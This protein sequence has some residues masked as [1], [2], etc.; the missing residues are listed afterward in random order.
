MVNSR[1]NTTNLSN[2][3]SALFEP[4]IVRSVREG[5][6]GITIYETQDGTITNDSSLGVYS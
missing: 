2:N 3:S 1:N 6:S 5:S 4:S